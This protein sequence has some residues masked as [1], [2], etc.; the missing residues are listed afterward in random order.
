[1]A[2]TKN[3]SLREKIIDYYLS[4][5]WYTILRGNITSLWIGTTSAA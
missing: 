4:H 3:Y 2:N 5:G 1:M